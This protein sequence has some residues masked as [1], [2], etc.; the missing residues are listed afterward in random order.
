VAWFGDLAKNAGAR[1][2]T[3]LDGREPHSFVGRGGVTPDIAARIGRFLHEPHAAVLAA[4]LAG[5]LGCADGLAALAPHVAYFS[6]DVLKANP[7]LASFEVLDALPFDKKRLRAALRAR[8][9]GRL[10][11]KKRGVDVDPAALERQLALDGE[12]SVTLFVA[13]HG[14]GTVAILARRVGG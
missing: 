10:E 7:L 6:S 13:P 4:D 3:V 8:R 14:A 12:E 5:E 2:A 1:R 11:I 9:V